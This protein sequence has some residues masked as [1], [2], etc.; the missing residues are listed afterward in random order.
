MVEERGH[1]TLPGFRHLNYTGTTPIHPSTILPL[2]REGKVGRGEAL[3]PAERRL[4]G[5]ERAGHGVSWWYVAENRLVESM[6]QAIGIEPTQIGRGTPR[7]SRGEEEGHGISIVAI[8]PVARHPSRV[9]P[10]LFRGSTSWFMAGN[11]SSSSR[12]TYIFHAFLRWNFVAGLERFVK[13]KNFSLEFAIVMESCHKIG[14][15]DNKW[16]FQVINSSWNFWNSHF[17]GFGIVME[18]P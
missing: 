17:F 15:E 4:I 5:S 16:I 14:I 13:L 6:A 10:I 7:R 18:L 9:R 1:R 12:L 2:T 3:W 8:D 11:I